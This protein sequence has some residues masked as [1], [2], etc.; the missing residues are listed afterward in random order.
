MCMDIKHLVCV[1]VFVLP[2]QIQ[3]VA[4][5]GVM[6]V[7]FLQ[8][9]GGGPCFLGNWDPEELSSLH[10]SPSPI[11][12]HPFSAN[13]SPTDP[14]EPHHN[15]IE[16]DHHNF[17]PQ[18]LS[19]E[20]AEHNKPLVPSEPD[21]IP[22]KP[23]QS[24]DFKQEESNEQVQTLQISLIESLESTNQPQD[25]R[26]SKFGH[27]FCPNQIPSEVQVNQPCPS[28][29]EAAGIIGQQ[30]GQQPDLKQ[31]TEKHF[32]LSNQRE[33]QSSSSDSWPSSP[34][35]NQNHERKSSS[36]CTDGQ[37]RVKTHNNNDIRLKSS[38]KDKNSMSPPA[39][40]SK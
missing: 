13:T 30:R 20:D 4:E 15:G 32:N 26:K 40:A 8:Q 5:Q 25:H 27:T 35:L 34:E 31:S 18:E 2:L 24:L 16:S 9:P 7:G 19:H 3:D 21:F 12:R 37:S 28:A 39:L 22:L 38:E 29:P 14:T 11:H 10:S 6:F 1:C 33:R 17:E 36:T 23:V